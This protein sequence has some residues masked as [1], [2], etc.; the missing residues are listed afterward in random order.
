V[1]RIGID[2]PSVQR[3]LTNLLD[4][5]ARYSP[6]AMPIR[7]DVT[8]HPPTLSVTD[9][10]PGIPFADQARIFDRY[11]SDEAGVGIGLALVKQ[12]A[13]AHGAIEVISPLPGL[14][15]GTRFTI[16]FR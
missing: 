14:D 10:G 6:P 9:H 13:D 2:G 7:I 11:H 3:A 8:E 16:T 5:A 1:L 15:H 4:N 12:I